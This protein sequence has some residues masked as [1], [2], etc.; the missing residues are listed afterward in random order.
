MEYV[1]GVKIS[2][3]KSL[4]THGFDPKHIST[5]LT[6]SYLEQVTAHPSHTTTPNGGQPTPP[7]GRR[8]THLVARAVS[9]SAATDSFIATRTRAT[10][11]STL[12]TRAAV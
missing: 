12:A 1:P 11:R 6:T 7:R 3:A 4:A 5:Q 10:S 2:D 9:R 8:L